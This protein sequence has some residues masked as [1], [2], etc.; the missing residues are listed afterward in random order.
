MNM[1]T[2]CTSK[3]VACE[4]YQGATNRRRSYRWTFFAKSAVD[5]VVTDRT[6][7]TTHVAARRKVFQG[8]MSAAREFGR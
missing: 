8:Y 1:L 7:Q 6:P 4:K 2:A 5:L 3:I